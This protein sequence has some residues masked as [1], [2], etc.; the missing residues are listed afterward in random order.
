MSKAA[1]K[2]VV[3]IGGTVV[4]LYTGLLKFLVGNVALRHVSRV[5]P[6]GRTER[7]QLRN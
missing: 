2:E 4:S 5:A 6:G 7:K 3:L 1:V